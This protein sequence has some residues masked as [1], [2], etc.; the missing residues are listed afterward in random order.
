[1]AGGDDRTGLQAS[2]LIAL[3]EAHRDLDAA[4]EAGRAEGRPILVDFSADWCTECR[5]MER[6]V[7]ADGNV[8]RRLNGVR[9]IRADVTRYDA[10]SRSIMKRFA[11]VGPPTLIFLNPM[12]TEVEGARTVGATVADDFLAKIAAA[13]RG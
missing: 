12:G 13:E 10:Q 5:L 7:L 9:L 3:R 6:T 4:I 1:M 8:R 11:V 2:R